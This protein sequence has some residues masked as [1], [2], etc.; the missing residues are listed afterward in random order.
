MS[1]E[2]HQYG[3]HYVADLCEQLHEAFKEAQAQ[4]TS[5]AE[6]QRQYYD[7]KGRRNYMKW[8]VEL[9]KVSLP[10]SWKTSKLDAHKSSTWI[11]LITPIMG[12]PLCSGVQAKWT[13]CATTILGEPT[14]KV[15][16]NEE[17]SQSANCLPP[18]QHQWHETPLGWVNRKPCAFLRM[19]L[20]VSLLGQGWKVQCRGKGMSGHQCWHS[21]GGGTDHTD[22]VWKI[23]PIMISSI[24]PLFIPEIASSK[25]RGYE[26]QYASL[27][28]NL[29]GDYSILNTDAKETPGIS[30]VRDPYHC[31]STPI[32]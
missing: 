25:H 17:V 11:F 14:Q 30:Y 5:E 27:C 9:L 12:A 4:S 32:Q 31:C 29:W 18:V 28:I 16:E 13:W 21:G 20:G 2:K 26:I 3:N 8:N 15:S 10:T 23:W 22:E 6:R 7:H 1:T 24:P 19:C